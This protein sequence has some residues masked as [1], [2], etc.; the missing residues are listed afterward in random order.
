MTADGGA[1]VQLSA[2]G[3]LTFAYNLAPGGDG[4]LYWNAFAAWRAPIKVLLVQ[5]RVRV[6]SLRPRQRPP[7]LAPRPRGERR[8]RKA[9]PVSG[10]LAWAA[11]NSAAPHPSPLLALRG[12][13]RGPEGLTPQRTSSGGWSGE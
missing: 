9:R 5:A 11:L 2:T 10:Y 6:T 13:A 3:Q 8:T 1:P 7:R 4:Y 12:E